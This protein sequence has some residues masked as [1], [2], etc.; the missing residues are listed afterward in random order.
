MGS[1]LYRLLPMIVFMTLSEL[2]YLKFD[3]KYGVTNKIGTIK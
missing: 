1:L 3:E 2:V